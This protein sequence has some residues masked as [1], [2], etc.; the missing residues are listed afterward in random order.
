MTARSSTRRAFLRDAAVVGAAGMS[1]PLARTAAATARTKRRINHVVVS[2]QENRSFD[3]YYGFAPFAGSAG[4]P[5]GYT[6]PDGSGGTFA[7]YEFTALSTPDIGHSWSA[8]HSCYDGGAMDQFYVTNGVNCMGYY[9]AAELPFYYS[10]FGS[11]TLCGNYF[12]SVMGPTW[13]N[14]FYLAAGTSG[15][16][17]TN[18]VWGYGVL[19]YPC[20]LDLL[21]DAGISWKVY[22]I[23]GLDNVPY[24]DSDNVYV[25]FKRFAHDGRTK[26]KMTDYLHDAANGTLPNV[27]FMIPSYTRQ[28]DEHPPAD[29]SV[30]M[31]YQQQLITALRSSPQWMQSAFILTY[32]ESGGF[33]D[34]VPPPQLDAYGLGFRVPT[35]VV[36][37][38]AKP[39]HIEPTVYEHTSVLK[40]IE[41]TFGLGTLAAINH[42]FDTSTPGGGNNEAAG[43]S[44]TGPPAPPR[45]E[46]SAIGDLYE[47]FSFS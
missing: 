17:T 22:N 9:T 21:E 19:D 35:W 8:M 37:P 45:D 11:S 18:G 31:R 16:V 20:I 34:H 46:L 28:A 2:C 10:L 12:H 29:V 7:P 5:L 23:G 40:F 33:F 14:R 32:D 39:G 25:F 13:P 3:H 36:S 15:G 47:C 43:G 24:G 27:S 4:V 26:K 44:T 38:W 30:G 42:Q 6:Q 41:R 1:L